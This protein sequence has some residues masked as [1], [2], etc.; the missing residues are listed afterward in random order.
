MRSGSAHAHV[1]GGKAELAA[2]L[3]ADTTFAAA[4]EALTGLLRRGVVLGECRR[5]CC[6]MAID[7]A[8]SSR[9][10]CFENL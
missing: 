8:R 5:R 1:D 7:T 3:A 4:H 2:A 10:T 9:R 6:D